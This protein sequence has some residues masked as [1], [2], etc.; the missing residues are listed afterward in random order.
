MSKP[1]KPKRRKVW[2]V[3]SPIHSVGE[4]FSFREGH[5]KRLKGVVPYVER[6]PGDVV[7]SR[8]DVARMRCLLELVGQRTPRGTDDANRISSA[9][10]LLRSRR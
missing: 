9:L 2:V 1:T 3:F 4:V 5:V 10:A 6:L 8:V 7:L